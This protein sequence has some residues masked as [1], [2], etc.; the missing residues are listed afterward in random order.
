MRSCR[1]DRIYYGD[2]TQSIIASIALDGTDE[3]LVL[4]DS[5]P[6]GLYAS[7]VGLIYIDY[8]RGTV[9]LVPQT[10]A[11]MP[12]ASPT[13]AAPFVRIT[14]GDPWVP[15]SGDIVFT[16]TDNIEGRE[17][18][19]WKWT[20][21]LLYGCDGDNCNAVLVTTVDGTKTLTIQAPSRGGTLEV[22]AIVSTFAGSGTVGMLYYPSA[23][24]Q[25]CSCPGER[26]AGSLD[27]PAPPN[28]TSQVDTTSSADI[29]KSTG[30]IGGVIAAGSLVALGIIGAAVWYSGVPAM[31]GFGTHQAEGVSRR[32]AGA[33]THAATDA[34]VAAAHVS[35]NGTH[36]S[37]GNLASRRPSFHGAPTVTVGAQDATV[38]ATAPARGPTPQESKGAPSGKP[39][40]VNHHTPKGEKRV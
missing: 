31:L 20:V 38:T 33:Q 25:S 29:T 4:R 13:R 5:N 17:G 2:Y 8:T 23:G 30:F 3:Q 27:G 16:G 40:K 6:V 21:T 19:Q 26:S 24:Q 10:G 14:A 37:K 11:P 35:R 9:Q 36:T 28:P 15:S 32:P 7:P 12:S 1:N 18:A 39:S 34:A 22:K